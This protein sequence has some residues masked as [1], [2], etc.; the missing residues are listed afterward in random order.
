M[1]Q[2]LTKICLFLT[3]NF[4][5]Q[6]SCCAFCEHHLWKLPQP[7]LFWPVLRHCGQHAT[8]QLPPA[9]GQLPHAD[10]AEPNRRC[11]VVRNDLRFFASGSRLVPFPWSGTIVQQ[12]WHFSCHRWH[13]RSCCCHRWH[14]RSCHQWQ[15]VR[16]SLSTATYGEL[17]KTIFCFQKSLI[18]FFIW[19]IWLWIKTMNVIV[20]YSIT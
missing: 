18:F 16:R 11:G 8:G 12:W 13:L 10:S 7:P 19:F 15:W 3:I 6:E 1:Y 2:S 4:V 5:L 20:S 17:R 14:L 9:T